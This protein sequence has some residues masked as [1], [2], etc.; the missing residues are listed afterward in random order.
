M[1]HK[2][3]KHPIVNAF[4]KDRETKK[5]VVY[6]EGGVVQGASA[7]PGVTL[8]VIDADNLRAEGKTREQIDAICKRACKGL[9]AIY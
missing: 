3:L 4:D 1:K 8:T 7:T 2:M 9:K 6:V 5:V